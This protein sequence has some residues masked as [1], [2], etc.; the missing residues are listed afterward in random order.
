MCVVA[1]E[2]YPKTRRRDVCGLDP[3]NNFTYVTLAKIDRQPI[4]VTPLEYS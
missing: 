3:K 2:Y 4:M 1:I